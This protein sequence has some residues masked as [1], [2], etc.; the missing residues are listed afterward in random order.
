MRTLYV[1]GIANHDGHEPCV[2]LPR[3][4]G[5]GRS[6]SESLDRDDCVMLGACFAEQPAV[7]VVSPT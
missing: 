4:R 1:E 2:G 3:R 5:V 7:W 6:P